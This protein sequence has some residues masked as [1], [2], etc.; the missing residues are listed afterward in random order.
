MKTKLLVLILLLALTITVDAKIPP[1]KYWGNELSVKLA[2]GKDHRTYN[3][4]HRRNVK[5]QHKNMY[6]SRKGIKLPNIK[7]LYRTV[8]IVDINKQHD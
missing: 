6:G 4:R 2:N 1:I 8:F 3:K 5:W 7:Q